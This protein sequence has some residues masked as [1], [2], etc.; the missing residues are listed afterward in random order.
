[1]SLLCGASQSLGVWGEL[2]LITTEK[3][4][5]PL[6]IKTVVQQWQAKV[7]TLLLRAMLPFRSVFS[8][9]VFLQYLIT[10]VLSLLKLLFIK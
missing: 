1:M 5:T 3:R 9:V 7:Y 2:L 6:L 4:E 10:A 8:S